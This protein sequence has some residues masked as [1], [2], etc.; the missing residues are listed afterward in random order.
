MNI[1]HLIGWLRMTAGLVPRGINH[2]EGC[3][4]SADEHLTTAADALER[5]AKIEKCA[6]RAFDYSRGWYEDNV[7]H[8][9]FDAS[10]MMDYLDILGE[11]LESKASLK[12]PEDQDAKT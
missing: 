4:V 1:E 8:D 2:A 5:L 9:D 10:M 3:D 6:R 12:S 7:Y 11:A